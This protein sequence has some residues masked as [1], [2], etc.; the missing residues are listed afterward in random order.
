[1][2]GV[3]TVLDRWLQQAIHQILSP[4][5][6]EGFSAHSY[7]FRPGRSAAQAVKAAQ[8]YIRSGKRW[9]VDMDLEKFFDRVN[10][11]VLMVRVAR[12]VKD[13]CMLRLVRRYLESGILQQGWWSCGPQGQQRIVSFSRSVDY[14]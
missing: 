12:K 4:L 14:S 10:H 13:Q 2:L 1:M 9:V 11:A 6:E 7:G 5:W 3:P 8:G